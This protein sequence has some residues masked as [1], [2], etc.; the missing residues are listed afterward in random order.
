MC[1]SCSITL[2]FSVYQYLIK[3]SD[4]R[5][6]ARV[7]DVHALNPKVAEKPVSEVLSDNDHSR[8]LSTNVSQQLTI[9]ATSLVAKSSRR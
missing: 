1:C 4:H 2:L 3:V 7:G 8:F 6:Y 9:R 5:K